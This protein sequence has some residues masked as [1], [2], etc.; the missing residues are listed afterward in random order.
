MQVK[1]YERDQGLFILEDE[2]GRI[3]RWKNPPRLHYGFGWIQLD[4]PIA[5]FPTRPLAERAAKVHRDSLI[6]G[7]LN[8]Q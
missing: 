4:G 6:F 2:K 5:T 3:A 1:P 7:R 8:E